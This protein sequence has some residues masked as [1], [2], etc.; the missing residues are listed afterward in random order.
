MI[1]YYLHYLIV[2]ILSS[3]TVFKNKIEKWI[4]PIV[5]AALAALPAF[6]GPRVGPD[7]ITYVGYFTYLTG[8]STNYFPTKVLFYE[9]SMYILPMFTKYIFGETYYAAVV[10][11][12]FAFL[13][14]FVKIKAMDISNSFFLSICLYWSNFYL[15][16]EMAQIRAGVA[17]G[18]C[19]ISLRYIISRDFPKFIL[20]VLSAAF[21]HYSSFVFIPLYWMNYKT[22]NKNLYSIP[23]FLVCVLSIL[24]VKF[25]NPEFFAFI[26]KI[27]LYIELTSRGEQAIIRIW[28]NPGFLINLLITTFLIF[29]QE[30]ISKCNKYFILLLKLNILSVLMFMSFEQVPVVAIRGSQVIG[31]VQICLFPSI[32]YGFEK[33]WI[34]YAI[35]IAISIIYFYNHIIRLNLFN[36][37]YFWWN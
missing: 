17:G 4:K 7:Y 27:K 32:I 8:S 13:G 2:C 10:F 37:Y 24:G 16:H 9:P 21:F 25:L 3:L 19:L 15:L 6:R 33:K 36:G 18:L 12:I 11:I 23:L 30:A 31:I 28:N 35:I 29:K 1:V 14:T 34:G 5:Y 20:L 22:F 26:P